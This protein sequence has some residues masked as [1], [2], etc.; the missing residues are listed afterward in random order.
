M[1]RGLMK[2][3]DPQS[4]ALLYEDRE[5]LWKLQTLLE[6][7]SPVPRVFVRQLDD[8]LAVLRQ[9][10]DRVRTLIIDASVDRIRDILRMVMFLPIQSLC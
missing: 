6:A 8:P 4:V 1:L 2:H 10:R 3:F 7:P 9:V 5:G